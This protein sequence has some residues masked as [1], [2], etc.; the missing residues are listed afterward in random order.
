MVIVRKIKVLICRSDDDIIEPLELAC[1]IWQADRPE[2]EAGV[3]Y[4]CIPTFPKTV[5]VRNL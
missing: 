5:R 3:K 4:R 2:T 1:E